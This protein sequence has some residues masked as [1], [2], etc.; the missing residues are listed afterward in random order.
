METPITHVQ[1]T[2]SK[3]PGHRFLSPDDSMPGRVFL[4]FL[5]YALFAKTYSFIPVKW[6]LRWHASA[7]FLSFQ[8]FF[9]STAVAERCSLLADKADTEFILCT[10][11]QTRERDW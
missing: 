9:S 5:C 11:L 2:L 4:S 7:P 1:S 3:S 8:Y 10:C 6:T